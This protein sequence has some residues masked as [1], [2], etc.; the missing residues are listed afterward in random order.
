MTPSAVVFAT[1]TINT[2]PPG[3]SGPTIISPAANRTVPVTIGSP[4]TL[5]VTATGATGYQWWINRGSGFA[6]IPDATGASHATSP[7]TLANN[8]HQ[9][10]CVVTGNGGS[11]TSPIFT[12]QV[13]EPIDVPATGD[14]FMPGLWLG[15]MLMA[16]AALTVNTVLYRRK[17]RNH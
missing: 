16:G 9:Y 4:A 3:P 6:I 11:V 10:Y 5:S 12:L 7:V 1:Y 15:I 13:T 17:R 2:T 8:G 14:N